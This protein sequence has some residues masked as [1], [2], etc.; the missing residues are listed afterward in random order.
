MAKLILPVGIP[1]S[2]KSTLAG[3]FKNAKT[4]SSDAIREEFFGDAARQMDEKTAKEEAEKRGVDLSSLTG[5]ALQMKKEDLCHIKVFEEMDR[6]AEE[7]LR[8]GMD[9]VYDATNLTKAGRAYVLETFRPYY[10]KAEAYFFDIP[11]RTAL[12]RNEKRE[13][14]VPRDVIKKMKK[15]LERPSRKEGFSKVH[16]IH[17]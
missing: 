2:G 9:V 4:V 14:K 1:G 17:K 3:R 8:S 6:R 15:N 12:K 10:D 7:A 5:E 13:R 16:V 11:L